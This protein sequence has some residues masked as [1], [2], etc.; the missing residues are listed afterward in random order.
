MRSILPPCFAHVT[1]A[2]P[3]CVLWARSNAAAGSCPPLASRARDVCMAEIDPPKAVMR[4]AS[5]VRLPGRRVS[6]WTSTPRQAGYNARVRTHTVID[7]PLQARAVALAA[8]ANHHLWCFQ[9][10]GAQQ[11]HSVF[12]QSDDVGRVSPLCGTNAASRSRQ[13]G[14]GASARRT[15]RPPIAH[16]TTQRAPRSG[17]R[18]TQ[19]A[20]RGQR[21]RGMRR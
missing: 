18:T 3:A 13:P 16:S 9:E 7:A 19:R 2:S 21:G 5:C 8:P 11:A 20:L 4:P 1:A 12:W 14:H 10:L 15:T 17:T 6:A